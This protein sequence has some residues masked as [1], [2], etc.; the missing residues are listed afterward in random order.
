V[1]VALVAATGLLD[2]ERRRTAAAY[3]EAVANEAEA[4]R[5]QERAEAYLG[6][7]RRAADEFWLTKIHDD[8][9]GISEFDPA[10]LQALVFGS[11]PLFYGALLNDASTNPRER[12]E[13]PGLTR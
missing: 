13:T 2:A 3:R 8:A 11:V 12:A 1:V 4:R 5:Q 6:R 7:M 10:N 9:V